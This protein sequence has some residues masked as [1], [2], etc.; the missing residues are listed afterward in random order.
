MGAGLTVGR[1]RYEAVQDEMQAILDKASGLRQ[2][3]LAKVAEDQAVYTHLMAVLRTKETSTPRALEDALRGAA[4]VPLQVVRLAAEVAQLAER[5]AVA[6]N[7]HAAADVTVAALLAQAAVR[8]SRL[9][10]IANLHDVQDAALRQQWVGEAT[11]LAEETDAR[12]NKLLATVEASYTP[13]PIQGEA[14][15]S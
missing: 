12:V 7:K 3:L 13:Q 4:Q 8:A 11:V 10:V 14:N 2:Q 6:G 15:A 9:N 5:L 1:G